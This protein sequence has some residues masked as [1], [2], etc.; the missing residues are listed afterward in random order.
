[1]N[2]TQISLSDMIWAA[3]F[4]NGTSHLSIK[5]QAAILD[6]VG[7]GCRAPMKGKLA[8]RLALPLSVWYDYGIYSRLIQENNDPCQGFEYIC[9]QDWPS[10]MRTL[11]ECM[12]TI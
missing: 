5:Q 12:T 9:G 10:E 8:R 7:K 3:R 4:D 6:M 2:K 11:R 1:M